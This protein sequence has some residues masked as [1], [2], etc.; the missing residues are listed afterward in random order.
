M[1]IDEI[2]S[3][4]ER[5]FGH[6]GWHLDDLGIIRRGA[7]G[8]VDFH[9]PLS[10][11]ASID[12]KKRAGLWDFGSFEKKLGLSRRE[13]FHIIDAADNNFRADAKIRA[14]LLAVCGLKEGK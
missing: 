6:Q 1:T 13:I 11:L 8:G 3:E 10:A 14:K 7:I 12:G 9:C 5:R 2:L 4:L